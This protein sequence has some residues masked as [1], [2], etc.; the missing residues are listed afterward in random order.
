MEHLKSEKLS[1]R[2]MAAF[3]IQKI[4]NNFLDKAVYYRDSHSFQ[5]NLNHNLVA[6]IYKR[7][8]DY[9]M[10]IFG[11][12]GFPYI[13]TI[14]NPEWDLKQLWDKLQDADRKLWSEKILSETYRED[15]VK[16]YNLICP[17]NENG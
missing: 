10:D 6:N 11:L 8:D 4:Q 2:T 9:R 15:I 16:I 5:I 3:I 7:D 14:V 1:A 12:S 17:Q 13:L